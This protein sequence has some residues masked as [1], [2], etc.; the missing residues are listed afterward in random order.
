MVRLSCAADPPD[1]SVEIFIS[2]R[3][4][5]ESDG[6]LLDLMQLG[7][8]KEWLDRKPAATR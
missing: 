8:V 4:L 7:G 6:T 1:Y 3:P 5:T 2:I